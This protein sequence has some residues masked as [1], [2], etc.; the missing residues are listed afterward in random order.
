M[1]S[2]LNPFQPGTGR[3]PPYLAG[4]EAEQA[5]FHRFFRTLGR[6]V[7]VPSE[8]ILYGPRGNGKT[9]LLQWVERTARESSGLETY[10]LVGSDIPKPADL[11]QRLGLRSVLERL[12]PESVSVAGVSASWR[13]RDERPLLAEALEARAKETPLV[14]LVDEAHTLEPKV[15]QWLLNA[16]Q[17]AGSRA[18]FLLILAGTPD[19]RARLSEMGASFWSRAKKV[20]VGRLADAAAGE[21]IR[22]PLAA[23][24]IEIEEDALARIVQESHGYPFFVQLWGQ[25]AWEQVRGS[26]AGVDRVTASVVRAAASAFE[27][28]KNDYYLDRFWE[29]EK[30]SLLGAAREVA[31]AF[32]GRS[33]LSSEDLRAAVDRAAGEDSAASP[34]DGAEAL[35]HLGFVWR[36]KGVPGWEPGIP[37]LMDYILEHAPAPDRDAAT[38]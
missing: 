25:A 38:G 9:A 5:L 8:V 16:A 34:G 12:V 35:E 11:V 4:R 6:G 32:L 21:A 30:M 24:G 2:D 26:A 17:V 10:W 14:V 23:D 20:A 19:L 27:E 15:G 28:E 7:P 37:S 22:Q 3:L 33:R 31:S 18:P 1:V 29:L 13:E 36:T